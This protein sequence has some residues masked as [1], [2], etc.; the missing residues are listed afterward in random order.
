MITPT[1]RAC[2]FDDRDALYAICLATGDAGNDAAPLYQDPNL[3]GHMYVGPYIALAP[4][5]CFVAEDDH[6]IAG[7]VCGVANTRAFETQ[8]EKVWWPDLRL[9]YPDSAAH[10]DRQTL[11]QRRCHM[12]HH[13]PRTPDDVMRSYPAHLHMN[14][15]PRAQA[16]GLGTRLLDHWIIAARQQGVT[17]AHIGT[18]AANPRAMAFWQSRGFVPLLET[19]ETGTSG[20]IWHGR[21]F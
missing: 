10:R 21:V 13:P 19:S 5:L 7:Y 4:D 2:R 11:D 15:L 8:M 12:I 14:V 18:G 9:R 20:T 3:I 1:L 6:G 16:R 17:A